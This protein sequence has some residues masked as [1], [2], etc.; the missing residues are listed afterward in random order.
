M[1]S[2]AAAGSSEHSGTGCGGARCECGSLLARLTPRGV[3]IKCRRCKR[4]TIVPLE[5]V[6]GSG[7]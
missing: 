2:K 5:N 3:E 1:P 6:S 4:I 7:R